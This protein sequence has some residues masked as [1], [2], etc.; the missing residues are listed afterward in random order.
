MSNYK[1]SIKDVFYYFWKQLWQ[2]K[3]L[4]AATVLT[5][6][7]LNVL[8]LMVPIYFGNIVDIAANSE[9][10]TNQIV[11]WVMKY[12]WYFVFT[13]VWMFFLWRV[14]DF[15]MNYS[16]TKLVYNITQNCFDNLHHH[17]YNFFVNNFAWALIKKTS[18]LG[19]SLAS[20]HDI[21]VWEI[22]R[23]IVTIGFVITVF[24][25]QHTVLGFVYAGW[26]IAFLIVAYYLNTFRIPYVK[27]AA[28]ESS[29]VFGCYSDTVTN[30]FNIKL[31]GTFFREKWMFTQAL[32]KWRQKDLKSIFVFMIIFFVV[33][34]IAFGWQIAS[35]YIAIQ[36][37]FD[38]LISIWVFVLLVTYQQIIGQ[39][40]FGLSFV[41][42][43]ISENLGNSMEMLD[44]LNTPHEVKDVSWA[45]PINIE[46]WEIKFENVDFSY[47][48]NE[49]VF[50]NFN[51]EIKPWEKV[52]VVGKSW[53]GKSTLIKLL[54]RFFDLD[55]GRIMIDNQ[56]ISQVRQ[57]SLR[58]QISMVPQD[59]I[60]FHRSL[61]ENIAYAN[62][63]ASREEILE[64]SKLAHCHEFISN[65]PDE[66]ESLVWERWVKLSGW[67]KQR[68]AI[69]RAILAHNKILVLDEATSSLDSESEQYIQDA[70]DKIMEQRTIIA[71]AHR[72]ST[73]MKMDRIIV[74][75]KWK[76]VQQW[77]HE[78]LLK[79]WGYYSK[80]WNIQ[81]WGF[82][83]N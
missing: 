43:R 37:W 63:D 67:E 34:T 22:L 49:K 83:S 31:F 39:Q 46:K 62:P 77:T 38:G 33:S 48:E 23:S 73:I 8:Q 20:M 78:E 17:S 59:P 69:A 70:L 26:I 47:N 68:V 52:A 4:V 58:S 60:L 6:V 36:L 27:A 10:S 18:R 41:M 72:L 12:F 15:S 80:L 21:I 79:Q 19:H 53:S 1:T 50:E 14:L 11:E 32:E 5:M 75:E 13:M 55:K 7:V 30:N 28:E 57:D 24:F 25:L 44:I 81:S 42:S 82:Q 51:L 16:T 3:Y 76:V 9:L 29:R 66:Y 64:A 54:F 56:D 45:K 2:I 40:L 74:M 35:L 61:K 65:L 71:V